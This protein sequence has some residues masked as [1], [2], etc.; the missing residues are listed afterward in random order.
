MALQPLTDGI[1]Q[2]FPIL[3]DEIVEELIHAIVTS[4]EGIIGRTLLRSLVAF[5]AVLPCF[6][7]EQFIAKDELS[8]MFVGNW[9]LSHDFFL[10]LLPD[11]LANLTF[12]DDALSGHVCQ[13]LVGVMHDKAGP[14]S[15]ALDQCIA[16]G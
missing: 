7:V 15:K 14:G 16:E 13:V 2:P 10:L 11:D 1:F 5:A 6:G 12:G 4:G 9:S 3:V 8:D